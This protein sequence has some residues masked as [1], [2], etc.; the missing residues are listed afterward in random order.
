MYKHDTLD[1]GFIAHPKTASSSA[2]RI[3]CE[4]GWHVTSN[5][6]MVDRNLPANV[7]SV[8]REPQDWYVSWYFHIRK[9]P[10]GQIKCDFAEWLPTFIETASWPHQR[11]GFI[12]IEQTTH[13]I[14]YKR[15]QDGWDAVMA[16]LG[17]EPLELPF[18]NV[19]GRENRPADEFFTPELVKLLNPDLQAQYA[20]LE[21]QLGDQ[22]YLRNPCQETTA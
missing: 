22:P 17:L 2:A 9:H 12:G 14:F 8:I 18:L 3:L 13:L 10:L 15:L 11:D 20:A 1:I 6:H 7:I 4:N 16:D 5:H 19:Q 21:A